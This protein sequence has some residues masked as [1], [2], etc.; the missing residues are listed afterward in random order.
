[1][2]FH[3]ADGYYQLGVFNIVCRK[4]GYMYDDF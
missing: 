3:L 4:S 1:M 2:C